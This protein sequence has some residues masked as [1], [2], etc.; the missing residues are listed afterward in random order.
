MIFYKLIHIEN[1]LHPKLL[2]SNS[3]KKPNL[4]SMNFTKSSGRKM[5]LTNRK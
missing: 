1:V 3:N 4:R 2:K 5:T